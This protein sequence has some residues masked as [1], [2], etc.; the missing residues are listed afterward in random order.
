[1]RSDLERDCQWIANH[2]GAPALDAVPVMASEMKN[3]TQHRP[4]KFKVFDHHRVVEFP[5]V[6]P[7]TQVDV[8]TLR[9]PVTHTRQGSPAHVRISGAHVRR[10]RQVP[11]FTERDDAIEAHE[12]VEDAFGR[13][14][15]NLRVQLRE[16]AI[17]GNQNIG[18]QVQVA[19]TESDPDRRSVV[20][21]VEGI[22]AAGVYD[23]PV[24]SVSTAT[25]MSKKLP[26]S[27]MRFEF[28]SSR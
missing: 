18:A 1:M 2:N 7:I 25:G 20:T 10:P 27:S 16:L 14:D 28:D 21:L 11:A 19:R 24:S 12:R 5:G 13:A 17:D 15:G 3:R 22:A 26:P 8:P 9:R 6:V 23:P 4:A